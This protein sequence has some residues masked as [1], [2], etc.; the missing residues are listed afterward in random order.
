MSSRSKPGGQVVASAPCRVDLAG[1]TLDLWPLYLFHP[2]ALTVNLAISVFTHC[3]IA[4][5]SGH[6]IHLRSLDT[7]REERFRDLDELHGAASSRHP[8]AA[9]A[10]KALA[11]AGGFSLETRSE[12]PAGAGISG[13]SALLVAVLG[14]LTRYFR[15]RIPREQ[16]RILAQN[17]E[18]QVIRVPTGCQDYYP[19]LY[20]GV[21]AIHLDPLR[22]QREALP[23][24]G[25]EIEKR[26]LLVYTGRPRRSGIN[27]WAVFQAHI[28]EDGR[29]QRNFEGIVA[30]AVGMRQ[31]L[32][33]GDWREVAL[34][35]NREWSL[36][37][38]NAPGITTPVIEHL[39]AGA[40]RKGALAAKVC[41]AGG[42]GCVVILVEP[43]RREA[44]GQIIA[45]CGCREI[46][47]RLARRGLVVESED[48]NP[49]ARRRE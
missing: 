16:M 43:E 8:L 20:G 25:Q 3:R 36:R 44:V 40:R 13:S 39:V 9:F 33:K 41:G 47:F 34:L 37:R 5:R 7:G 19:A 48:G 42:G 4:P 31:A 29:V 15:R 26:L 32:M 22:V 12:S 24:P 46:P 28:N 27:N 21:S 30:I 14:A 38:R 17:I 1:G 35:L 2:G 10:V 49:P 45:E 6:A 11:T 18:A 23:V